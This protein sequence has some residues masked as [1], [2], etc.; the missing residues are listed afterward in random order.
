MKRNEKS[1]EQKIAK[2]EEKRVL[3]EKRHAKDNTGPQ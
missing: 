1:K 3:I 2:T